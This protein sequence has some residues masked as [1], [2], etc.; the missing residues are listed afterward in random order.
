M[1]I[2]NKSHSILKLWKKYGSAGRRVEL[3]PIWPVKFKQKIDPDLANA[4]SSP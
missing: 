4:D 1:R 2:R 3:R